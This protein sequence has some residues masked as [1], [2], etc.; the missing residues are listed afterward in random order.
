MADLKF[1][2]VTPGTGDIKVGSS[3]ASKIYQGSTLLWPQNSPSPGEVTVCDL[4]WT[5]TNSTI[6]AT[7]SG[8]NIPIVTNQTD[9]KNAISNQQAAAC[10]W[11][12]DS[13]NAFRGLYYNVFSIEAIQPPAGFRIPTQQDWNDLRNCVNPVG[14]P[15]GQYDVTPIGNNYYGFYTTNLPSNPTF[16]TVAW[17]AISS[18]YTFMFNNRNQVFGGQGK[19]DI[20]WAQQTAPISSLDRFWTFLTTDYGQFQNPGYLEGFVGQSLY[21][22]TTSRHGFPMR[23]VKDAPPP[24]PPVEFYNNDSQ[25]GTPTNFLQNIRGTSGFG[26]GFAAQVNIGSVVIS[27]SPATLYLYQYA[28]VAGKGHFGASGTPSQT[29]GRVSFYPTSARNTASYEINWTSGNQGGTWSPAPTYSDRKE[30]AVTVPAGTWY[31]QLQV[32]GQVTTQGS[33]V[34]WYTGVRS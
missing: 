24:P 5:N 23:F 10:Y 29:G 21:S 17:N 1:G 18:G 33:T 3:N 28:D 19:R 9:W 25:T 30:E 8:G 14:S 7:T 27:G 15:Y 2:G 26:T 13:N 11:D 20:Y 16:G 22:N 34:N 6:T 12:F 31:I 4:V 32:Y